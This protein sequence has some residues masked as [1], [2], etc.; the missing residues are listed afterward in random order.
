MRTYLLEKSRVV[1][2]A[3]AERNYHIFYQLCAASKLPEMAYLQLR[4]Q[5]EYF[6]TRQ[7]NCPLVKS[8]DDSVEFKETLKSLDLL[9]FP[10]DLQVEFFSIIAAV[11]HCGNIAFEDS[12]KDN[13]Q[14]PTNDPAINS[15]C[16]L[17]GLDAQ[18][19]EDMRKY[20]C[21]RE[22]ISMREV[23][24]KPMTS[25]EA[26]HARNA[27]AK[28]IYALL[29]STMVELINKCLGSEIKPNR[30]IGVLDIYGFETFLFNSFEQFCINY[31]NEKLQQQFN[32]HVFK[33]EQEEYVLEKIEWKF[34]EYY[35]N[36]PCIDL[37]EN[38]MGIFGLLDEECR[39]PRG[40]D[41]SWIEKLYVKCKQYKNFEKPRTSITAFIIVHFADRVQY[42]SQGFLEKNRDT[43]LEDQVEVLR[44][45]T[46][47]LLLEL[48]KKKE[49]QTDV[50]TPKKQQTVGFQFRASLVQLVDTLNSTTP[51]YIR[52]IKPNDKKAKYTMN[53]IRAMQQLRAC[54]VLETV[55]IS[56]AGFPSRQGYEEFIS[57][58]QV[59]F[60]MDVRTVP[61]DKMRAVC[62]D[63]MRSAI[64]DEDKYKLGLTKMFFRA[65]Q[66]AFLEKRRQDKYN[67]Y[68]LAVQ[69]FIRAWHNREAYKDLLRAIVVGQC[70]LRGYGARSAVRRL[71][72]KKAS[73][74]IQRAARNY[75]LRVKLLQIRTSILVIQGVARG[76]MTRRSVAK[77]QSDTKVLVIQKMVRGYLVRKHYLED[78]K[79]QKEEAERQH[80]MKRAEE[81]RQ[82]ELNRAEEE[83]QRELN[84]AE[85]ER[86]ME[87]KKQADAERRQQ[88]RK[89]AEEERQLRRKR[90]TAAD[91][92]DE[93]QD[94]DE[95]PAVTRQLEQELHISHHLGTLCFAPVPAAG[96]GGR[97]PPAYLFRT[98]C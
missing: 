77:A 92:D 47:E 43:V 9:G 56:S 79:K 24:I 70:L 62:Q 78:I 39:M 23:F 96:A 93:K 2:Q 36:Q 5:S 13:C 49:E 63:F 82:R 14:I 85:E 55:R 72:Q 69:K 27:L 95:R 89:R 42:E 33:L 48:I 37:I 65:G 61:K 87:Q 22:I 16:S 30:F 12:A 84:R 67:E 15:F 90:R 75:F 6:Y 45:S 3:E 71:R 86:Q 44:S 64:S 4:D 57:R 38:P 50:K 73:I 29:F 26:G 34:I 8:I 46:N 76:V 25:A 94:D 91:D 21:N 74:V 52:C 83:R 54:G 88:Q 19:T 7:G 28:H 32:H 35:D 97:L 17:L 60:P 53:N 18:A 20:F 1:F 80:E 81:E 68:G 66:V 40:S 11:L 41:Q 59:L 58:Y 51:H 31:A 98:R 10:K